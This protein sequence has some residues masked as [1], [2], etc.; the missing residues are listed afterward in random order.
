MGDSYPDLLIE[1]IFVESRAGGLPRGHSLAGSESV[2]LK[3]L[4]DQTITAPRTADASWRAFWTLRDSGTEEEL[5]QRIGPV[6]SSVGE[7][8]EIVS[9][10]MALSVTMISMARLA[11][12][13][14]IVYRP[15]VDVPGSVLAL[16][17]RGPG[18][19]HTE[20]FRTVANPRVSPQAER[21]GRSRLLAPSGSR[22]GP[23]RSPSTP[24][25]G[26]AAPA[27]PV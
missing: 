22:Q 14:S 26:P 2:R 24:F 1:H 7:E 10:G 20:A 13:A 25:A 21:S 15:I 9:A 12:R 16:A 3:D 5:L 19:A 18:T 4:A 11:P 17:W 6:T 8:M 23:A 27:R